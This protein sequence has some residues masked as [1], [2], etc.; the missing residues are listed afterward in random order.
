MLQLLQPTRQYLKD[1]PHKWTPNV[2]CLLRED[3][4]LHPVRVGPPRG[5][6][7]GAALCP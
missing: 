1:K 4:L 5:L 6:H 3:C 7:L 2:S